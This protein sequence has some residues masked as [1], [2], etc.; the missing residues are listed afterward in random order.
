MNIV[1][2]LLQSQFGLVIE[3]FSSVGARAVGITTNPNAAGSLVALGGLLLLIR[4]RAWWHWIA[5]YALFIFGALLTG[6]RTGIVGT[7]LIA[8]VAVWFSRQK[9]RSTLAFLQIPLL[10]FLFANVNYLSG[11]EESLIARG[12]IAGDPRI[13]LFVENVGRM[14]AFQLAGGH[15]LGYATNLGFRRVLA[16]VGEGHVPFTDS[17]VTLSIL[18]FGFV[19]AALFFVTV[20]WFFLTFASPR[21]G[22]LFLVYFLIFGLTGN[23]F[24]IYPTTMLFGVLLGYVAATVDRQRFGKSFLVP[25][26]EAP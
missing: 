18:Q 12:G 1:V 21:V 4:C 6:S 25:S 15:G 14:D 24:E 10:I 13:D 26:T 16:S 8:T 20:S 22:S 11:R 7:M 5:L 19:G 2:S 17:L 23:L 9:G 3:G